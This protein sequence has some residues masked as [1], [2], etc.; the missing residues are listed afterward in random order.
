MDAVTQAGA[1]VTAIKIGP[2][3]V[4]RFVLEL[5]AFVSLA[6][7]GFS[8]W[9]VPLNIVFGLGAPLVAILLWALFR[10]PKA[11]FRVDVYA[12]SLVELV[13]MGAAALSWLAMG[14]P[15]VA[16]VFGLVAVISGVISGRRELS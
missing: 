1:P 13:V 4:L 2:N 12:K 5:F 16:I 15:I 11:V 3:D 7:W 6:I 14:Q 8:T 9:P 10:S